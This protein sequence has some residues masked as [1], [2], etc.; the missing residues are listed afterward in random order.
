MVRMTGRQGR[1]VVVE[2]WRLDGVEVVVSKGPKIASLKSSLIG[3]VD[4]ENAKLDLEESFKAM[5]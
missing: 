2:Q 4:A 1:V 5:N 3:S